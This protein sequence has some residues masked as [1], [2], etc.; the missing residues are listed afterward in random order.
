MENEL[1]DQPQRVPPPELRPQEAPGDVPDIG[2]EFTSSG[3]DKSLW[4]GSDKPFSEK[5]QA[6]EKLL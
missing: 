5:K 3:V 4:D 2:E 6:H 1:K